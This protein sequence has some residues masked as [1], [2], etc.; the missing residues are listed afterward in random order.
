MLRCAA[1]RVERNYSRR[2]GLYKSLRVTV[3][4]APRA[5]RLLF[6]FRGGFFSRIAWRYAIFDYGRLLM[7]CLRSNRDASLPYT[8]FPA[9]YTRCP[10]KH[11]IVACTRRRIFS[12]LMNLEIRSAH[13]EDSN[14]AP[15]AELLK[16][17]HFLWGRRESIASYLIIHKDYD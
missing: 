5:R 16:V 7:I 8:G 11:A 12:L 2:V 15:I 4:R 14:V 17:P 1:R 13:G 10:A 9:G 3:T 6:P